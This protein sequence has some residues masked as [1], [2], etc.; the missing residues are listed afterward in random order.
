[1]DMD[2]NQKENKTRALHGQENGRLDK[3][4][5]LN[6]ETTAARTEA[7]GQTP[8]SR[9]NI[10]DTDAVWNAKEWVDNGSRL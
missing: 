2:R 8:H 4:V 3:T 7:G 5:S 9:V 1:M 10:P 6:R